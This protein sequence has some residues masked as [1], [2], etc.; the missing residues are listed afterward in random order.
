MPVRKTELKTEAGFRLT[1]VQDVT[2]RGTVRAKHYRLTSL[3]PSEPSILARL[4]RAEDAFDLEV[5]ASLMDPV[6]Q[7]SN[8]RL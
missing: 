2:P 8:I 1:L 3:R 6:V 7:R 4:E 5:I